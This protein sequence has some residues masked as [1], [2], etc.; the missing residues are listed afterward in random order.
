MGL[1][2]S[3]P[4]MPQA[5][6][7]RLLV[8][9]ALLLAG[10]AAYQG[11]TLAAARPDVAFAFP[12]DAA[13][14]GD[15][16]GAT[17]EAAAESAPLLAVTVAISP[18][19]RLRPPR[20]LPPCRVFFG[21]AEVAG[22]KL[23][24]IGGSSTWAFGD[25]AR[26]GDQQLVTVEL[27]GRRTSRLITL[28][29]PEAVEVHLGG[30][31]S[32]SGSVVDGDGRAV[33]GARVWVAGEEVRSDA[34]GRFA[35][36]TWAGAGLAIAVRAPGFASTALVLDAKTSVDD[37][38]MVLR[39]AATLRVRLLGSLASAG[40]PPRAYVLPAGDPTTSDEAQYPYF[41]QAVDAGVPMSERGIA[42]LEDLP[43]DV[44]L[45]VVLDHAGLAQKSI[46]SAVT[47]TRPTDV[48]VDAAAGPRLS[49][50]ILDAAGEGRAGAL[51]ASAGDAFTASERPAGAQLALPA[52]A[53]RG[54]SGV[55]VADAAGRFSLAR[56][57]GA[58]A[59]KV[60]VGAGGCA[61]AEMDVHA[62]TGDLHLDLR[63]PT[64]P[65]PVAPRLELTAPVGRY[66]LRIAE[67]GRAPRPLVRWGGGVPFHIPLREWVLADVT[68][69]V[70][71]NDGVRMTTQRDVAV[72]GDVVVA[73]PR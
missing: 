41:L 54:A 17:T 18:R 38:R 26:T 28:R 50:R 5:P 58:S 48:W 71:G 59:G 62:E 37:L 55:V 30:D 52:P 66:D 12:G 72:L 36:T 65:G 11:V 70:E 23:T 29:D 60:F 34:D 45:R 40:G 43:L 69:R 19:A 47:R 20:T 32:V 44:R 42:L 39:P 68:V 22:A 33:A 21:D 63:L 10:L 24:W 3:V 51:I 56:W 46:P 2:F 25:A 13:V 15:L 7:H 49:G 31:V 53:Y 16:G 61:V 35:V 57:H 8:G 1:S 6:S 73:L 27:A 9:V 64:L 14:V 67:V 4:R